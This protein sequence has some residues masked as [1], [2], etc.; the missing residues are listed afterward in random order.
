MKIQLFAGSIDLGIVESKVI[1]DSMGVVGG[2]LQPSMAY[3]TKFQ[4]YFRSHTLQSNWTVLADLEL[5]GV[6]DFDKTLECAGGIC[7]TD[8]EECDEINVEFCGLNQH[9]MSMIR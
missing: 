4:S 1:D 3:L 2:V 7:L 8:I 6:I 9:V 5:K